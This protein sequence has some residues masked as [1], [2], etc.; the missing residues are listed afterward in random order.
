VAPFCSGAVAPF[1][2][3]VDTLFLVT[4]QQ[5]ACRIDGACRVVGFVDIGGKGAV[6]ALV[7]HRHH[8]KVFNDVG[9]FAFEA[10]IKPCLSG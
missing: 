7:D 6:S 10:R 1:Y 2:S 3:G 5:V 9:G 8:K 4:D